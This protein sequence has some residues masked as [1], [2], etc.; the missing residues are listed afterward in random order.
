[1][2]GAKGDLLYQL[3]IVL[4]ICF[5]TFVSTQGNVNRF[6]S[7]KPAIGNFPESVKKL[8]FM[9]F[10]YNKEGGFPNFRIASS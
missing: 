7:A 1:M 3:R 2:V 4:S 9:F 10:G 8:F 5:N 6:V